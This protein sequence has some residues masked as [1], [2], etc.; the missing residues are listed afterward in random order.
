MSPIINQFESKLL[1]H[2][3]QIDNGFAVP[4]NYA[5]LL[6]QQSAMSGSSNVD[7]VTLA[8]WESVEVIDLSWISNG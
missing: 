3:K 8:I 7:L 6:K 5:E 1:F 4:I 2:P